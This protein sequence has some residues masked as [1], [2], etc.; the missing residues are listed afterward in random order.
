MRR[1][2]AALVMILA[3]SAA[4]A[5][6]YKQEVDEL[7]RGTSFLAGAVAKVPFALRTLPAQEQPMLALLRNDRG[8]KGA[9][10]FL[11]AAQ[12]ACRAS[13]CHVVARFD[14]DPAVTLEARETESLP[15]NRLYILDYDSFLKKLRRAETLKIE[16][17]IFF[18]GPKIVTFDVRGLDWPQ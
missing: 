16:L 1:A 15:T 6:E 10:I 5:W 9:V 12:F 8:Q 13:D 2:G 3:A 14:D 17:P 18:E 11:Q 4:E 7:G